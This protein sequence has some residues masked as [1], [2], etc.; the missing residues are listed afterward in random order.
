M[1]CEMVFGSVTTST[2]KFVCVE[3]IVVLRMGCREGWVMLIHNLLIQ[4]I[5][6][7]HGEHT[8]YFACVH[9]CNQWGSRGV[10]SEV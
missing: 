8:I 4:Q 7:T 1:H 10:G 3:F 6:P 2:C 5:C 9:T